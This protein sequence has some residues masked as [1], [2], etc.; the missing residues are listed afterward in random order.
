MYKNVN[1]SLIIIFTV[2]ASATITGTAFLY[3]LP[4]EE[5]DIEFGESFYETFKHKIGESPY[6]AVLSYVSGIFTPKTHQKYEFH[7]GTSSFFA[8]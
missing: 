2:I 6:I 4:N 1:I 8:A 7:A 3:L 5:M